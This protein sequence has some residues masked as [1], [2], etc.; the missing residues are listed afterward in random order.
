MN[1]F[2]LHSKQR[3]TQ[4]KIVAAEFERVCNA[5]ISGQLAERINIPL[6]GN[7]AEQPGQAINKMLDAM[8]QTI[9][10]ANVNLAYL[11]KGGVPEKISIEFKGEFE[12]LKNNINL[13]IEATQQQTTA[14]SA[15]AEGDFS[16]KLT[17]RSEQD[18]IAK[19]L[20]KVLDI[21]QNLKKELQRLTE[22]SKEGRLTKRANIDQF[23]GAYAEIV[24]GVNDILDAILIPIG[25]GN[26]ILEQ[27]SSGKIDELIIQTYQGDH[28]KMRLSVNNVAI[29]MQG[30]QNELQ[31]LTLAAKDGIL[32]KRGNLTHFKGAY[33]EIVGDIN[34][35][36]DAILL[37]IAEGNRILAQISSGKIDELIMQSYQGDH[38][39]MKL[40]VNNVAVTLQ[41]LQKELSRLT[42]ASR[43]GMLSKRGN[44]EQFNGAYGEIING[45]NQMLDAILIPIGEGNR[46][47]AQISNGKIDELVS[48]TYQGDH[49]KMKQAVN[50]V[51]TTL[52]D[53]QKELH[54]L[55]HA[56]NEGLLNE[57]GKPE[58]Y[59]GAYAEIIVGVNEMLDAILLPIAEGNRILLLIR[60]GDLRQKVEI[61]CKGDHDKMKQA[62]NGVHSWLSDLIS[63]VTR[64]ANGD[65]TA[66]MAK[67]SSDDQIHAW[68]MLLKSNI[69]ALVT[70][71]NLL[72][73]SA[74][75]G[76]LEI[77]ADADKHQGDFRKVVQGMNDSLNGVVMPLKEAIDILSR[78]ENGELTYNMQGQYQGQLNN[79]KETVNNTIEKLS[80]TISEVTVAAGQLGNAS[81][82]I[83]STSQS[84]SQASA[85]QAASV[86]ETSA[87]VEQMASIIEQNA[88]NARITD[89]M[90]AKAS[91][92]ATQGGVAVK[93]TVTAMR[94]IASKIGIIDDIAYQ[95]N[96]LALNAAIEAA[97][98]GEHG[99][100]FAVVAA[101]VR[102]LAE[103][104][105][106]AAREIS[107]L[108]ENSVNTAES[109]GNLLDA[110][111]PSIKKTSDLVQ[112]IAS[113]S[114]EQSAGVSQ[115]N[116]A[117][118][119]M[120]QVT[121]QNAS[122]SQQLA[123]TAEEMGDQVRQLQ[124][125]M[126][127]FN[128]GNKTTLKV[129]PAKKEHKLSSIKQSIIP[130]FKNNDV[131]KHDF[132]Q[133][134]QF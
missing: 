18:T 21:Q 48:L 3:D 53:L 110:I 121:Q 61:T 73:V 68:L 36:L 120:N 22:A 82:Q 54:R 81:S 109:A 17:M 80:K 122:A 117:M 115:I 84:L 51:A 14:I 44:V 123:A 9:K 63:F 86:E 30:L 47:L 40:A 29:T 13:V 88:E 78:V 113:A 130:P 12:Q 39:K 56:S 91:T 107:S 59:K 10:V 134:E 95:T 32:S 100:G 6:L 45:V 42:I 66:E 133:F 43:E 4:N 70:D 72:S 93:Q 97:R 74:V 27:I 33:A 69:Q 124:N 57:R 106:V 23:K 38:E 2:D 19:N 98:A 35:M 55:T 129:N 125:L 114:K 99:K 104:S 111:V 85:E 31:H 16:H 26:R 105:Q 89:G 8:T 83:G 20:G 25:E 131:I 119:Q 37:P 127:F 34:H 5:I 132:N 62:V 94:E 67:A 41:D 1:I 50:L 60:G 49:E 46:I 52:Q 92:E 102:K 128:I 11:A 87:S 103:R 58:Q 28:E 65:M 7:S 112:E 76:Q 79:F 71:A 126:D 90:A 64:I 108:A 15:L 75:A 77:R 118:N 116:Q 101:E 24:E 96:M